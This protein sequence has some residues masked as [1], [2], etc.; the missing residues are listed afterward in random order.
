MVQDF[1]HALMVLL[2]YVE[3]L[4]S[5]AVPNKDTLLQ[6]QLVENQAR[7]SNAG[8]GTIPLSLF[9]MFVWRCTGIKKKIL[10]PDG[11]QWQERLQ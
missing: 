2:S 11:L 10:C 6:E 9:K 4:S 3:R 5:G 7:T 8:Q 1:V